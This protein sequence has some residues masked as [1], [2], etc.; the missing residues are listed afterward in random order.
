MRRFFLTIA[1]VLGLA[2]IVYGQVPAIILPCAVPTPQNGHT[3]VYDSGPGC[4][5]DA[6]PSAAAQPFDDSFGL[7]AGHADPSKVLFFDV[8]ALTTSTNRTWTIADANITV[9]ST[10]ASLAAN[11]FTG[12][13]TLNGGLAATTGLFSST[14]GVTGISTLGVV[15][16]GAV[17]SSGSGSFAGTASGGLAVGGTLYS[18]VLV[19]IGLGGHPLTG[20]HQAG[21]YSA[22]NADSSADGV[23]SFNAGFET[24]IGTQ[25]GEFTLEK[26]QNY[27]IGN[28]ALGEGSTITRTWGFATYEETSGTHN[29]HIA[30]HDAEFAGNWF[31]YYAGSRPSFLGTG[32]LTIGKEILQAADDGYVRFAGGDSAGAGANLI[33]FGPTHATNANKAQLNGSVGVA[34]SGA[35]AMSSYG[36]GTATFDASGNITS[37]S[38]EQMK[39]I[40]GPYLVGLSALLQ[41]HPELWK[42]NAASG[43]DTENVYAGLTA[44]DVLP[45]IPEAV[46]KNL[47]GKYLINIIPVVAV[48]VNAVQELTREVDELRAAMKF[49]A[50]TRTV[51]PVTDEKRIVNSAT[52]K[53]LAELAKA[54]VEAKALGAVK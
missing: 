36:A 20:L 49:P 21:V 51:V 3:L 11:T 13:Q 41:L 25:A 18:H 44:Q 2:P 52:P 6:T 39:D 37:V 15:N 17:T 33:L 14:L 1:L 24:A 34:I 46:G 10:I 23:G 35:V 43:L 47:D 53:R 40:Q 31:I 50:K 5:V 32:N 8:S 4:Y 45:W 38:D 16:A 9:P 19:A 28:I 26:A 12:L 48:T 54:T 29:A 22:I 27:S 7:I 42:Y 30:T